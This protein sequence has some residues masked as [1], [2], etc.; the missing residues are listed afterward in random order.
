[1]KKKEK[2][3]NTTKY[4][5][6]INGKKVVIEAESLESANKKFKLLLKKDV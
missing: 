4:Q 5:R 6:F 3:K 2:T 1:M